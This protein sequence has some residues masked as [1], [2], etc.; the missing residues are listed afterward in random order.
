MMFDV[1][2]LVR[3]LLSSFLF[4]W[5]KI[6]GSMRVRQLLA[7]RLGRAGISNSLNINLG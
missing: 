4:L 2:V 7:I 3:V 1:R 5:Q 6:E